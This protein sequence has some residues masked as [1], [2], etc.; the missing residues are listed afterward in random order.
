M[1]LFLFLTLDFTLIFL[2]VAINLAPLS[3]PPRPRSVNSEEVALKV[4][5]SALKVS[6]E[7]SDLTNTYLSSS[8]G[9]K[10]SFVAAVSVFD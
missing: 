5:L 6:K 9:K 8:N 3:L 4:N 10:V 2:N 7:P 1:I